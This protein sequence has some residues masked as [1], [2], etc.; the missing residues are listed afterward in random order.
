MSWEVEGWLK[1]AQLRRVG[2][3]GEGLWRAPKRLTPDDEFGDAIEGISYDVAENDR[4]RYCKSKCECN[5]LPSRHAFTP[6]YDLVTRYHK[7]LMFAMH[8]V[9]Q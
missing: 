8:Q 1:K 2:R 9:G 7:R 3:L 4:H 6:L 5:L